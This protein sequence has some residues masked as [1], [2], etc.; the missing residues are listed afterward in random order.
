MKKNGWKIKHFV[1][2]LTALFFIGGC[3]GGINVTVVNTTSHNNE[4]SDTDGSPRDMDLHQV[5]VERTDK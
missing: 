3:F 2:V 4:K 5:D 1:I